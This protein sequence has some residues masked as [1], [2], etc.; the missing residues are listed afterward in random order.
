MIFEKQ[1]ILENELH[2]SINASYK[3]YSFPGGNYSLY[4]N[5]F[6]K[7]SRSKIHKKMI[8]VTTISIKD[9]HV[10]NLNRKSKKISS[11]FAA[12]C[13]KEVQ[14]MYLKSQLSWNSMLVYFPQILKINSNVTE[15][16]SLCSFNISDK[17]LKAILAAF[18]H[19]KVI[20]FSFSILRVLQVS[21]YP[22]VL[23]NSRIEGLRFDNCHGLHLIKGN[24]GI[25]AFENLICG[26]ASSEDFKRS[27]SWFSFKCLV[28]ADEYVQAVLS[29][30][31]FGGC[32]I[33]E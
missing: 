13:P 6:S 33:Q 30:N 26:L 20:D 24:E 21:D 31:G 3:L 18:R 4:I 25:S 9:M 29:Q 8:P 28:L 17:H 14:K 1:R 11:F 22:L 23:K 2:W 10:P 32:D 15:E 12:C 5:W 27:V 19:L 7:L 16:L